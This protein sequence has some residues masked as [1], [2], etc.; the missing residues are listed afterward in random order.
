MPKQ[1]RGTRGAS[2]ELSFRFATERDVAALLQ[3]RLAVH[4]DQTRRFGDDGWS[5]TITEK[6]V[7]RAIR[8]EVLLASRGRVLVGALRMETKKPWAIDLKYFTPACKALYLHDV[9]VAPELQ[10]SGIGRQLVNRTRS[11]A[12]EWPVDAVRVDTY[13]GSAGAATFYTRCG[14]SEV[15]RTVYRGVPLVY[16]EFVF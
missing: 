4:A 11:I 6:S 8:S 9:N 10:R 2:S 3:L 14:F 15:G 5:T 7:A 1:A 16:L 13:D 12:Q